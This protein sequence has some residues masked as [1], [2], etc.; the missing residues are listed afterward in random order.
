MVDLQY[1]SRPPE[2]PRSSLNFPPAKDLHYRGQPNGAKV[3]A[4]GKRGLPEA[5]WRMGT[6]T[7]TEE[8]TFWHHCLTLLESL[9]ARG[10]VAGHAGARTHTHAYTH[11]H[12]RT[13][14]HTHKHTHTHTWLSKTPSPIKK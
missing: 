11:T 13:H 3:L 2:L 8:H 5:L 7:R 9:S 4:G 12:T 10:L 1:T 6:R 14:V